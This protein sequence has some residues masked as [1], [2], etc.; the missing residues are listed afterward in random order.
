MGYGTPH[1]IVLTAFQAY[2]C[3]YRV[4][5]DQCAGGDY[6]EFPAGEEMRCCFWCPLFNKCPDEDGI[7]ARFLDESDDESGE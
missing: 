3:P 4:Q 6:C 2:S 5:G 7:C 1:A